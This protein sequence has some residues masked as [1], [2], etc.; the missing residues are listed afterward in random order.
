MFKNVFGYES[1]YEISSDG[2]VKSKKRTQTDSLGRT[3]TWKGQVLNPDIA[4]NGYYRV[5][6]AVEGKKKTSLY[7][8]TNS[9]PF[10]R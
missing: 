3:R 2:I 6:L 5:T 1:Y 4:P 8:Q 9:Y 10:H 7:T